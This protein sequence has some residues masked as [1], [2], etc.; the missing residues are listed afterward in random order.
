MHS[1]PWRPPA[2]LPSTSRIGPHRMSRRADEDLTGFGSAVRV[3]VIAGASTLVGCAEAAC[4][5]AGGQSGVFIDT[6]ALGLP[7]EPG[8]EACLDDRCLPL[9]QSQNGQLRFGVSAATDDE[10]A[11]IVRD[12]DGA[13]LAGPTQVNLEDTYPNGKGCPPK[14]RTASVSVTADGEVATQHSWPP[15]TSP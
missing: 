1:Q 6:S 10:L 5:A 4:T 12:P 9:G 7:A 11:F 15:F 14:L 3:L 2:V 13:A 8:T